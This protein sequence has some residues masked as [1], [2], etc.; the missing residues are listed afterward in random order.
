VRE[1]VQQNRDPKDN[2]YLDLAWAGCATCV[3][4]G[5]KNLLVLN[6]FC[7]IRIMTPREF[8]ESDL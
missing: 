5:D 4:S 1:E 2:K 8:L 3:I 6:P 7:G